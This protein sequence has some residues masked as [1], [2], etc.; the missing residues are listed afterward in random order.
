MTPSRRRSEEDQ[1]KA[2]NK[3]KVKGNITKDKLQAF[4]RSATNKTGWSMI[5]IDKWLAIRAQDKKFT[6]PATREPASREAAIARGH[7]DPRVAE[8]ASVRE[9]VRKWV[10]KRTEGHVT[11][12]HF[13][14]MKDNIRGAMPKI[15]IEAVVASMEGSGEITLED[16]VKGRGAKPRT[17]W[18][19]EAAEWAKERGWPTVNP[20]GGGRVEE[21]GREH[22]DVAVELGAGWE[23]ATEGLRRVWDRVITIDT[24]RQTLKKREKGKPATKS[25]PDF[26]TT[27]QRAAKHQ[28]GAAVWAAQKG[29][30]RK[31][32]LAAAWGSPDCKYWTTAQGFQKMTE[33]TIYQRRLGEQETQE[34]R[35]AHQES[36][37]ALYSVLDAFKKARKKDPKFQYAMEQPAWSE[38]RHNHRVRKELGEG[39]VI[40]G[41]AYGERQSEK[42]YRLWMSPET[43]KHFQ[44]IDPR[45]EQSQC[46]WCKEGKLHPQA[47]CPKPGQ[48]AQRI[49][50]AGYTTA[51]ARNRVPPDLAE[52]VAR[53]QWKGRYEN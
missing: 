12:A 35:L 39:I 3:L 21:K 46:R 45:S 34:A 23:G 51:A 22:E 49:T 17:T 31:G 14:Q 6:T 27:F 48:D 40:A 18:R 20:A 9:R 11:A 2:L 44:A 36:E 16:R 1:E 28:E 24:T 50:L 47:Y 25:T 4:R 30:A 5:R 38:M 29:G 32:E 37:E 10:S 53:A 15:G 43:E 7:E 33:G 8:F 19:K 26:L 42:K 41:C 52:A 13:A